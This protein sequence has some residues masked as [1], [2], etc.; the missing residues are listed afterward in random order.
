MEI[1]IMLVENDEDRVTTI[2]AWTPPDIR[3]CWIERAGSAIGL[4]RTKNISNQTWG[5]MLDY[6]LVDH[7]DLRYG[8]EPLTGLDVARRMIQNLDRD[9]PVL[10]HSM[11]RERGRAVEMLRTAGFTV[12]QIPFAE[13]TQESFNKWLEEVRD[14]YDYYQQ[15]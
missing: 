7:R 8:E 4:F 12:T 5:V 11:S 13:L 1:P 3:V 9:V 2:R 6:D 15:N 14:R 10:V